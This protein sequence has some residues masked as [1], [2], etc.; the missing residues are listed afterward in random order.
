MPAAAKPAIDGGLAYYRLHGA[1]RMY[2][3]AYADDWLAKLATRM[4]K[5]AARGQSVWCIFDNTAEGAALRNA[6]ALQALVVES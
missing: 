6:L 3:S 5:D 2:Y 1:P 4:R